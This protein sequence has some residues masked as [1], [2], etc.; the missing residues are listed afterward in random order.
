M[1]TR[2]RL[3]RLHQQEPQQGIALLADVPQPLLA[4]TGV[5]TRNHPH[6]VADLLA[7]WKTFPSSNDQH[8]SQCR[9][10]THPRMRPKATLQG[11]LSLHPST[12]YIQLSKNKSQ[13]CGKTQSPVR[14]IAISLAVRKVILVTK[15]KKP[16]S[17]ETTFGTYVVDELLGEGGAGRVYGGVGIDGT[18]IAL[19]ILAKERATA[20]RRARFKNE[21]SFLA[22][23]THRNIVT[24][25]DHGVANDGEVGGAFYVM[26]R[27]H[28][29]LRDL[30]KTG[31]AADHVMAFF[32]QVLDGVEAAHLLGVV[33]RDLKPE[34][35]LYNKDSNILAVADFG[36]ARFTEDLLATTV[37]TGPSQRLANFEY[38]APEQRI[39]G[40]QVGAT[41]DIHALGLMLNEMF[42]GLV[43]HRTQYRLIG[44][45]S[46]GHAFLDEIIA[47]MLRQTP[48]DRPRSIADLKGLIQKHQS[49]AVS[50]QRLSQ[51]NGTVIKSDQIDVPLA[52][53]PPRLVNADWNRGQLVLT[54]DRP[55]TPQWINA[56]HQMSGYSSVMGKPPQVFSFHGNQA[57]VGAQEHE[58]QMVIDNFKTWLPM[59][60]RTL[61]SLL[62]QAAQKLE[63]E[64]REELR[65][66]RKAEEQRLRVLRQIKI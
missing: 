27:Y 11:R 3:G 20:D 48:G 19:K 49:E 57:V 5:L 47:Q 60:S 2:C 34:N 33:H 29:N 1:D 40:K 12:P 65:L 61:K 23:N 16:I 9:K 42:T 6:V 14:R 15:L 45:V 50:L 59:A 10:R 24:V 37:E 21:I 30:M 52:E 41:A 35:I 46:N 26:R 56:L 51:I 44:Q 63:F 58:V 39:P 4:S 36:V 66:E 32:S 38:A 22:R 54:L 13:D 28:A 62:E 55:V 64:K 31:I 53:T 8:E 25:I 18:P 17:F 43:P 7:A